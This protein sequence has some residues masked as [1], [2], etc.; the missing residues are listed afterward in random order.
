[1]NEKKSPLHEPVAGTPQTS[2]WE[3]GLLLASQASQKLSAS[4]QDLLDAA[5]YEKL[6]NLLME[7]L[8]R[9]SR[10]P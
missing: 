5:D 6:E 9:R 10:R 1:M 2:L 8:E 4:Y 7:R 3:T